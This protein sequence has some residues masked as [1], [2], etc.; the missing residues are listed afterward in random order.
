[1]ESWLPACIRRDGPSQKQG[2]G[3]IPS[4]TLAEIEGICAHSME[5]SLAA[6][7]GELDN[8]SRLASWTFSN[9]KAGNVLQHYP[10]ESVTWGSGSPEANRRFVSI[11][12]EGWAGEPLTENQI[13][14]LVML[15]RTLT[16]EPRSR[17][18]N[19][20]EHNE[21]TAYGAQPTACPSGR[22]PWAEIIAELQEDDMAVTE[23]FINKAV[24]E[25]L[26]G[27]REWLAIKFNELKYL[28]QQDDTAASA[29]RADAEAIADEL[30]KR[31]E[32]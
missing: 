25:Q 19:L 22:I 24:A 21:M 16:A 15:A 9:P 2:Y 7:L 3:H 6:A 11:E 29:A 30:A 10:L 27:T 14:N 8:P 20:R 1:M 31:L 12:H 17:T 26:A 32:S 18:T 5:G 4:R 23:D 13:T 28:I